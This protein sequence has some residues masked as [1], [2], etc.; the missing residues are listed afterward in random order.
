V[1]E[2]EHR[3]RRRDILV[4][5]EAIF[6]FYDERVGREVI[7]ARHF[8]A[9]WKEVRRENPNLLTFTRELLINPASGAVDENAYP[10][11]WQHGELRFPLRYQFDPGSP[12]DG[13]TVDIPLPMLNHVSAESFDWQVPGLREELVI[14]LLRSL[15]K[16]LRRNFVPIPDFARAVLAR[17]TP[18]AEPLVDAVARELR[19]MTGVTIPHDAW[20]LTRIPEYLRPNFRV[21][22]ERN[23]PIAEGRDLGAL[24][25]RLTAEVRRAVAATAHGLERRG[26]REW[27]FGELPRSV[28]Q[29]RGGYTVTAYPALVDEGDS[30]AIRVF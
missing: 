3:T 22:D 25:Q 5:D 13:V 7:S 15:P 11:E 1:E 20:D 8:D 27:D 14:A 21:L 30:V 24:Q 10:D 19:R 23:R 2:L 28:Q 18:G 17:I 26:L 4:D 16:A 9:W 6:E 29:N 12:A